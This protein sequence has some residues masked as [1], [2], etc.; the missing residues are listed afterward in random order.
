MS[1]LILWRERFGKCLS[2]QRR[3]GLKWKPSDA[4]GKAVVQAFYLLKKY[5]EIETA[6]SISPWAQESTVNHGAS[7][8]LFLFFIW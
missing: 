4:V 5:G 8:V 3:K 6:E 1:R 2:G 7:W